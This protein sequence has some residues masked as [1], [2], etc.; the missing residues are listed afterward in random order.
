MSSAD[1][2]LR[3]VYALSLMLDV[4]K[5]ALRHA[6]LAAFRRNSTTWEL[7]LNITSSNLNI[8]QAIQSLQTNC[9]GYS[10]VMRFISSQI[11]AGTLVALD[12]AK[13][14]EKILKPSNDV[15]NAL[16]GL[17]DFGDD[18]WSGFNRL[19]K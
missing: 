2:P 7:L 15:M 11:E 19:L 6:G 14:S 16:S 12:G 3:S 10:S 9:I 18:R 13:K 17:I 8:Q 4:E 1:I 5:R